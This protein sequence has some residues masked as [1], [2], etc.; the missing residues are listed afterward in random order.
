MGVLF[1]AEGEVCKLE[2]VFFVEIAFPLH[3]TTVD[4]GA[5]GALAIEHD[6]LSIAND[7]IGMM[8]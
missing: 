6:Q 1:Q 7:E 8:T 5:V 3:A 4:I 2:H